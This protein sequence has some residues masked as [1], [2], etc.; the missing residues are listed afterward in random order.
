ML[1]LV[2]D[3]AIPSRTSTGSLTVNVKRDAHPPRFIGQPYWKEIS[4]TDTPNQT[5]Y[6]VKADDLD[7]KV[8]SD[9][10]CFINGFCY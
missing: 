3:L 8:I 1:V 10:T 2:H 7:I 5:I 4:E 6:Q 9:L